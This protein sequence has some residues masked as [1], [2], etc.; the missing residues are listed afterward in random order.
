M[1]YSYK[2]WQMSSALFGSV[3]KQNSQ[4]QVQGDPHL[5]EQIP[6]EAAQ[7]RIPHRGPGQAD[8]RALEQEDVKRR[9]DSFAQ[10]NQQG[11]FDGQS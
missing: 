1:Y 2:K 3:G 6:I 9:P 5:A 7:V 10:P 4:K 11:D 8:H